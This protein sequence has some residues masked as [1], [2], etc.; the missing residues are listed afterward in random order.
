MIAMTRQ[1]QLKEEST[2]QEMILLSQQI[3]D[4]QQTLSTA[5]SQQEELS[6]VIEDKQKQLTSLQLELQDYN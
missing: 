3:N 6:Q 2:N 4:L 1:R 5:Q